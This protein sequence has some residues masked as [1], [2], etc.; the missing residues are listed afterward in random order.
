MD[1]GKRKWKIQEVYRKD[2]E[3]I[4]AGDIIAVLE[5]PAITAHVLELKERITSFILTDSCICQ[6]VFPE[7]PE[8]GNI[9]NAYASFIKCL[10]DYRNFLSIDLYAQKEQAAC[11]ELQE[12]QK[13]IRHLNKQAELDEEQVQIA[14]AT[15][16]RERNSSTKD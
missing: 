11:K 4:K 9:Q 13:Y 6:T 16:S 3:T 5:N 2:R 8:L 1:R 14:S 10:T 7:K 12:Y 15:H